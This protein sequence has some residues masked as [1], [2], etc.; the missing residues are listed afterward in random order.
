VIAE[1]RSPLLP[2]SVLETFYWWADPLA[3]RLA[4]AGAS[5]D[6]V[7]YASLALGAGA[8]AAFA[9]GHL[10]LGAVLTSAGAGAD[11]L[12]GLV[13]RHLGVSS[14]AGELLDAAADRYVDFAL[15]AG[16]AFHVR[17]S[18]LVLALVLL[19]LLAAVMISYSTAKADALHVSPPRGAMR[20]AERC[21]L[22]ILAAALSPIFAG[23]LV[24]VA[25]ACATI[26]I[27]GNV[28]ARARLA[29]V[30]TSLLRRPGAPIADVSGKAAE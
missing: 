11:A 7:T 29:A 2:S 22:V 26:G 17:G 9:S 27:L 8:G 15:F 28:S 10:G 21:V 23:S 24:P 18:P 30:R 1:G 12:D 20:R 16:L 19:A 3:R 13:A 14:S 6:Q 4:R 5:P 25:L